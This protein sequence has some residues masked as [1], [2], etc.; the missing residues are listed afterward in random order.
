MVGRA[1]LIGWAPDVV[2]I[3]GFRIIRLRCGLGETASLNAEIRLSGSADEGG[4]STLVKTEG[5]K[6][7][8]ERSDRPPVSGGSRSPT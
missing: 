7:L 2:L 4:G 8:G 6:K 5:R 1:E 3:H